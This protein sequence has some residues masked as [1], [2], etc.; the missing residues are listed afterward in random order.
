M[1]AFVQI[2]LVAIHAL[3]WQASA[4]QLLRGHTRL[5][6]SNGLVASRLRFSDTELKRTALLKTLAPF[7]IDPATF[8]SFVESV[9]QKTDALLL[10][11]SPTC[12][13]CEKLM[14]LWARVAGTFEKDNGLTVLSVSDDEGRAPAPYVH[15]ENP[16]IFFIPKGDAAHPVHFPMSYLHEFVALPE[17]SQSE[18]DIVDRL[19]SFTRGHATRTNTSVEDYRPVVTT[20]RNKLVLNDSQTAALTARLLATLKAKEGQSIQDQLKIA[21]EPVYQ[22][23]PVVDFLKGVAADLQQPL[24]E[25]AAAY[26]DGLPLATEWAQEYARAQ[27]SSLRSRGWTPTAPEEQAYFQDLVKFALPRYASNI[28]FQR[29]VRK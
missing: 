17:T 25:V 3:A 18:R 22:G 1:F 4:S 29:G 10:F 16:E 14:P 26:L 24:A 27:E 5:H 13:D 21:L 28:Y 7:D 2:W 15:T 6:D 12:P 19:V 11:F 23:L 8:P 20:A 9:A